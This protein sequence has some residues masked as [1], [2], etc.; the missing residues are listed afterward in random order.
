M[1]VSDVRNKM[2]YCQYILCRNSWPE[3]KRML[4]FSNTIYILKFPP[5]F[6]KKENI[7]KT[8]SPA[9]QANLTPAL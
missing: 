7:M 1:G 5:A 8:P 4:K 3:L 9:T 2:K 6:Y